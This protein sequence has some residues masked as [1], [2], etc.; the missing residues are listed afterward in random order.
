MGREPKWPDRIPFGLCLTHGLRCPGAEG[1]CR[2]GSALHSLPPQSPAVLYSG[3]GPV[4]IRHRYAGSQCAARGRPRDHVG[5]A[6][7]SRSFL[8]AA[9]SPQTKPQKNEIGVRLRAFGKSEYRSPYLPVALAELG[10][11]SAEGRY[12]VPVEPRRQATAVGQS[13]LPSP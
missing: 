1:F 2:F 3:L 6:K 5:S 9:T 12:N 8:A 13:P 10:G 11:R 4:P 7:S